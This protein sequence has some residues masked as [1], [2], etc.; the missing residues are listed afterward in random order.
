MFRLVPRAVAAACFGALAGAVCLVVAYGLRPEFVL[1][2]DRDP[3]PNVTGFHGMERSGEDT[4]AWTSGRVDV[5]LTGLDR[6]SPWSCSVRFRGARPDPAMEQPHL[7]V[8]VDGAVLAV[9]RA[10]NEFQ[11]AEVTAPA[12][13]LRR[14]LDLALISSSTFVP[15]G[16][17][18]RTLG[19]QVD[20]LA[21]HP[22]GAWAVLPPRRALWH[23]ALAAATWG[24]GLGLTGIT[25][26]SALG[27]VGLLAATQAFPLSTG[28]APYSAYSATL[29]RLAVWIALVMLAAAK[30]TEAML[31]RPLR[32]TARFVL[33]F[34]ASALYLTL[35]LLF[36]PAKALV[37]A[38][39]HAHRFEWVLAG[40]FYFTQLSTSATAFPYAIG[41][42]LFAAPLAFLTTDYVALL[43]IVVCAAEAVTGVLLYVMI[44]RVWGDRLIG[45]VAVGFFT[46]VPASYVVV[47]N[48]NLTHAFGQSASLATMAAVTIWSLG[49]G[50]HAQWI[51]VVLLAT[52]G[53]ISHVSTLTLLLATLL[54]TVGFY[55]WFGGPT[56][57]IPAR[58]VL[59][60]TV[61][62]AVLAVVLYW[63]HF[64]AVYE[65]QW[66]RMRAGAPVVSSGQVSRSRPDREPSAAPT[67]PA[68]GRNVIPLS[69]RVKGALAQ[70]VTN[71]GWPLLL[72]AAI[73][74]WRVVAGRLR[75]RLVCLLAAWG[76]VCLA[77]VAVSVVVP[78]GVKY[79]QD[80][81]EFIGRVEH[82]TYPAAVILAA[83]GAMWAW[84]AGAAWRAASIILMLAAIVTGVHAWSGWL[85]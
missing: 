65:A 22:V 72:L 67:T 30:L 24:A 26:G 14:G 62:V 83:R 49:R 3:P 47:G 45:A 35:L 50:Q 54:A 57:R 29:V 70:T 27:A 25:A 11:D 32:N 40:R 41:L 18:T 7:Q 9:R 37:D 33:A 84:R 56:L 8:V 42:Y 2:L 34:S 17:D 68:L 80:A 51:G 46:L 10:T 38:L 44:V 76:T 55:R 77:F 66:Q 78:A 48:A 85:K 75:D 36:H 43:R 81:W 12:R 74:A 21:C 52:L 69:G 60:A 20:R 1:E 19:V 13:P 53:F 58:R 31:R 71:V 15:G 5:A 6:R 82:A 16:S 64:G 39:F 63:G 79:Q 59:L 28:A 73:G 23:A 61:T 4:L